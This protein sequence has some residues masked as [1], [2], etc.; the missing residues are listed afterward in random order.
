MKH[1]NMRYVGGSL[2]LYRGFSTDSFRSLPL[3]GPIDKGGIKGVHSFNTKKDTKL[4]RF[5]KGLIIGFN[6]PLLPPKILCFHNNILV[7][8]FRIIGGISVI[9]WLGKFYASG[10]YYIVFP[11]AMLHLIYF[12]IICL[13][14][15][16]YIVHLWRNGKFEVRNSPLD[17]LAT[18]AVKLAACTKGACELGASLSVAFGLG[19]GIDEL[20]MYSGREPVFRVHA[21][22]GL[23][24]FLTKLGYENSTNKDV[25][26][27]TDKVHIVKK[28]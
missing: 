25:I 23:D 12:L 20:L 11:I 21:G 2:N 17:R 28:K 18:L 22:P 14:K 27:H 24:E 16:Y 9:T 6:M 3:R 26:N 4:K 1:D 13:I 15:M 5:T 19:L 10:Y 8:I 7:R